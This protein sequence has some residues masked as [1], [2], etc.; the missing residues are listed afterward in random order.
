VLVALVH[1]AQAELGY[2]TDSLTVPIL[3]GA[4]PAYRILRMV[5]SGTPLEILEPSTKGYTKIKT[6][7]GK[8]GWILSDHLMD[9]PSARD[10]VK[11]L[12]ARI[13]ALAE[14][15]RSLR[16]QIE[17]LNTTRNALSRCGEELAEIRRAASQTL[18]I[19]EENRKLQQEV[20]ATHERQRHLELENT[21][22]RDNSHRNWFIT[23][24]SVALGGL[25]LGLVIPR[26]S[27]RRQRRWDSL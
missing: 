26:L 16:G 22:M 15:N 23:G 19:E 6:P 14:E 1:P 5:P 18:A 11:P 12:E 27:W 3:S 25:L 8:V 17:T 7:E 10:R 2:A 21:A 4:S 9:Q 20:E 24:A 13:A